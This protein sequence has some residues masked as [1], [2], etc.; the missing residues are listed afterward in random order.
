MEDVEL[1]AHEFHHL[2]EQTIRLALAVAA[3][4]GGHDEE[5]A[6]AGEQ[7]LEMDA[8]AQVGGHAPTQDQHILTMNDL[9]KK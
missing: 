7:R 2:R 9:N 4:D 8:D 1:F 3:Q 5:E 6:L